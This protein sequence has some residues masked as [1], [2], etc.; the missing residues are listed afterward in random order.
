MNKYTSDD[1]TDRMAT[2]EDFAHLN[3]RDFWL[4][5]AERFEGLAR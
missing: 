3:A 1:K 4:L 2:A 5:V